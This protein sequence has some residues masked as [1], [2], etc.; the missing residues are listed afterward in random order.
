MERSKEIATKTCRI[1]CY[2]SLCYLYILFCPKGKSPLCKYNL[3]LINILYLFLAIPVVIKTQLSPEYSW[4]LQLTVKKKS[5]SSLQLPWS[6]GT[7]NNDC[8]EHTLS[9]GPLE[10]LL[11]HSGL[12]ALMWWMSSGLLSQDWEAQA[13]LAPSEQLWRTGLALGKAAHDSPYLEGSDMSTS[14]L[15]IPN[16]SLELWGF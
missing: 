3:G 1:W 11:G 8:W 7:E 12:A 9:R 5:P 2:F 13:H 4:Q 10:G 15:H 6:S 16:N 14:L